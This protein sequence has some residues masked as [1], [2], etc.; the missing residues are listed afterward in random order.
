MKRKL[1]AAT[2]SALMA[3]GM[4]VGCAK[5]ADTSSAEQNKSENAKDE[6][7]KEDAEAPEEEA[8]ETVEEKQEKMLAPS[9]GAV[10]NGKLYYVLGNEWEQSDVY[11]Y[12][13]TTGEE[14]VVIDRGHTSGFRSVFIDGKNLYC[15]LDEHLGSENQDCH[16]Y[17]YDLD[18]F[19]GEEL[20]EGIEAVVADD[21]LY[22]R[23]EKYA[24]NGEDCIVKKSIGADGESPVK[25]SLEKLPGEEAGYFVR[26]YGYFVYNGD[27]YVKIVKYPKTNDVMAHYKGELKLYKLTSDSIDEAE[28]VPLE[29]FGIEYI[30][31]GDRGDNAD[32]AAEYNSGF[33]EN[34]TPVNDGGRIIELGNYENSPYCAIIYEAPDGNTILLKKWPLA[35]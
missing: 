32:V 25:I 3:I 30:P 33:V 7:V 27:I 28:E 5:T 4:F 22:T 14:R 24:E 2:I 18:T 12:D 34:I 26:V 9:L 31:L 20:C 1:L 6:Q 11:E 19:E 23:E 16:I 8:E 10:Y 17:R 15:S 21:I 13:L 35:G 29:D